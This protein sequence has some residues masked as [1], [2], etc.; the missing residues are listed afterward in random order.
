VTADRV[1]GWTGRRFGG[2]RGPLTLLILV[3]LVGAVVLATS[4][5]QGALSYYRTPSELHAE[6]PT[7]H[8]RIRVGGLVEPGSL[9]HHGATVRFV[10]T[11]GAHDVD[12]VS[13]GT[14]PQ[15]FRAGKGAVVEGFLGAGG[16][17]DALRVVVR[18]DNQYRPPR[19]DR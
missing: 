12:V 2:R 1:A 19:S 8:Q 13:T 5:F 6:P 11:D 10:L 18:H 7:G 9:Q 14:P 16:V 3:V 15:T 4:A 17:F